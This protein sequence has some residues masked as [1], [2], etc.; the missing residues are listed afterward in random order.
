MFAGPLGLEP[1]W[2]FQ[3]VQFNSFG[4]IREGD[5]RVGHGRKPE[6]RVA[7]KRYFKRCGSEADQILKQPVNGLWRP[8]RIFK[9]SNLYVWQALRLEHPTQ[10]PD[11]E[12]R[13][14]SQ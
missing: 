10:L 4:Q 5:R 6:A 13:R 1:V 3:G 7:E 14:R 2:R 12:E 9:D 8:P 11:L